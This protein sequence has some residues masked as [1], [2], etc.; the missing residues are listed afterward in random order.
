MLQCDSTFRITL[1]LNS[2]TNNLFLFIYLSLS[3]SLSL[4]LYSPLFLISFL[5]HHISL[6]L[7]SHLS[8]T[9]HYSGVGR[10][11]GL[12]VR[13]GKQRLAWFVAI[14]RYFW[15]RFLGSWVCGGVF[16]GFQ[17]DLQQR[18]RFVAGFVGLAVRSICFRHFHGFV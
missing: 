2:K 4:S 7:S 15:V 9:V 1:Q 18:D 14:S 3:L 10:G 12:E 11:S 13:L 16:M 17:R 8:L 5:S 6:S